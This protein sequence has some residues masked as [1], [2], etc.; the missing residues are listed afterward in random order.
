M[1]THRRTKVIAHVPDAI[2]QQFEA[3]FPKTAK[4]ALVNAC[5]HTALRYPE[6]AWRL[7]RGYGERDTVLPADWM[8][9]VSEDTT[10]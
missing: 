3:R 7:I 4:D 8:P 6:L 5:F 1:T 9:K 2:V 10:P